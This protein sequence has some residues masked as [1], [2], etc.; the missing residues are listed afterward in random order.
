M[1]LKDEL[2]E[3]FFNRDYIVNYIQKGLTSQTS[4][5]SHRFNRS[6]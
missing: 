1:P 4:N 5:L 3:T 6:R 2:Q